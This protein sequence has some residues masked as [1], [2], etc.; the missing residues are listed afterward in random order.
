MKRGVLFV[1]SLVEGVGFEELRLELG[2]SVVE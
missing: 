1:E 2:D